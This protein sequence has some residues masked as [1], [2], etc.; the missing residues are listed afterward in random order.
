MSINCQ[1]S[2]LEICKTCTAR[3][4]YAQMVKVADEIAARSPGFYAECAMRKVNALSAN[5]P[6]ET[7]VRYGNDLALIHEKVMPA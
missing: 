7:L 3:H 2:A 5:S 1:C 6:L 4:L